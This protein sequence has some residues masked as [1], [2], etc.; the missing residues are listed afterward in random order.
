MTTTTKNPTRKLF[1]K[2][3]KISLKSFSSLEEVKTARKEK[4]KMC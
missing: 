3:V 4:K 1:Q 2:K